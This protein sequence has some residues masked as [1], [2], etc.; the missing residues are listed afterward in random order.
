MGY[1]DVGFAAGDKV[2]I[3]G[4]FIPPENRR[5]AIVLVHGKD[6]SRTRELDRE[7]RDDQPGEFPNLAVGLSRQGF[8]VLMIDLRG[9][10]QSGDSRLAFGAH[11][12]VRRS[13]CGGLDS[14]PVASDRA[15]SVS[16]AF[17]WGRP[18]VSEAAS[19]DDRIGASRGRQLF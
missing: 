9:H 8:A 19:E 7:P 13:G 18:P 12:A 15:G 1:E 6:A 5:R 3:A 16:S 2:E 14:W 17:R 10:G 4:W 11:G